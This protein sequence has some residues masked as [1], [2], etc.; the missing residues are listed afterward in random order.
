MT[1]MIY[2][3]LCYNVCYKGTAWVKIF[4]IIPEFRILRVTFLR[5]SALNAE[6]RRS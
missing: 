5:K 2:P 4:R 1:A 3:N 6:L